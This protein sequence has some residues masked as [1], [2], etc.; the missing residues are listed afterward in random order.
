M[1]I[2]FQLFM[3]L[4]DMKFIGKVLKCYDLLDLNVNKRFTIFDLEKIDTVNKLKQ[5][6]DELRYYY[7][8]CKYKKFFDKLDEK[9]SITILRHFLRIID[10]KISSREKY[11]NHQKYLEYHLCQINKTDTTHCFIVDF[12]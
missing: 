7:L 2:Y 10:Y 9:R 11:S 1:E 6:E 12:N 8:P 5:L 4:P 3:K